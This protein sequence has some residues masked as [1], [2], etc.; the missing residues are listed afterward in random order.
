MD[1]YTYANCTSCRNAEA[2]ATAH[3]IAATKR[4]IFKDPLSVDELSTLFARIG[5][6]PS[7]MVA[8]RSRP[9]RDLGLANQTLSDAQILEL[10]AEYPALIRRP[11]VVSG[12]DSHV[13]FN[14]S[15]ID[16]IIGRLKDS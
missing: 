5:V 7:Q 16:E 13:G 8:T 10:M 12:S 14:R 9:Y 2:L 15:A 4:D 6:A 3:G 11:I 1:I